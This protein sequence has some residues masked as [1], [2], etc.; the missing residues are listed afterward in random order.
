V[1]AID[2]G[3][4]NPKIAA[5]NPVQNAA[6]YSATVAPGTL[7]ILYGSDLAACD[8]EKATFPLPQSLCDASIKV[9]GQ[10]A[11]MFYASPSQLAFL[12]PRAI[13]TPKA[14]ATIEVN[15]KSYYGDPA[16]VSSTFPI[17]T[18]APGLFT[19]STGVKV[20]TL[21]PSGNERVI[22]LGEYA[23]AFGVGLGPTS[24]FTEDGQPSSTDPSKLPI[25]PS[26]PQLLI[27]NMPQKLDYAGLI[28]GMSSV[29]QFNWIM[30][31]ATPIRSGDQANQIW[32]QDGSVESKH[33]SIDL[34]PAVDK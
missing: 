7:S 10:P 6:D 5:G 33:L 24:P 11:Y 31:P 32:L 17:A 23:I 2:T 22:H 3:V 30:N 27:N 25:L 20:L 8:L 34:L 28:P 14:N 15:T 29:Y 18:A 1:I 21:D 12:V 19:N 13:S 9:D 26:P 4:R 16:S